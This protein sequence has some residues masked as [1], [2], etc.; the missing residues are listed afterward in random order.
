MREEYPPDGYIDG[1]FAPTTRIDID[2]LS[3]RFIDGGVAVVDVTLTEYRENGDVRRF[4]GFWD[5]VRRDGVWLM[6]E[7][8]F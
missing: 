3:I 4:V 2:R 7:P 8:H 5:L 1:R 6:D